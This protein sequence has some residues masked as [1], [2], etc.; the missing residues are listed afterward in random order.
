V[1][2]DRTALQSHA[3]RGKV[4]PRKSR[5]SS[6]ADIEWPGKSIRLR[7]YGVRGRMRTS[8]VAVSIGWEPE[9]VTQSGDLGF[10]A[11]QLE[12]IQSS[13]SLLVHRF[14]RLRPETSERLQSAAAKREMGDIHSRGTRRDESSL[15]LQ[16]LASQTRIHR[17][18]D[19]IG[20]SPVPFP[21]LRHLFLI[22]MSGPLKSLAPSWMK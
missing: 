2:V 9:A 8:G 7:R 3:P 11:Y 18:T 14:N 1:E 15:G 19:W 21:F 20:S 17:M 12:A 4:S 13:V 10:A 16:P 6:S 5:D 22:C